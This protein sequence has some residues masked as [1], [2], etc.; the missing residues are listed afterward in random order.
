VRVSK[1][2]EQLHHN[3]EPAIMFLHLMNRADVRVV[4]RRGGPC[5]TLKAAER[6]RPLPSP[7]SFLPA[8]LTPA[9]NDLALQRLVAGACPIQKAVAVFRRMLQYRL[10]QVIDLF[11]SIRVHWPSRPSIQHQARELYYSLPYSALACWK[12]GMPGSASFQRVRKSR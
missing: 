12:I 8:P 1:G 5:F 3:H 2:F 7:D 10:Q 9:G 11:P 4:Q 6:A